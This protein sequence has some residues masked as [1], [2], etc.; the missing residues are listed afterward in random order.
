MDDQKFMN[1]YVDNAVG[2]IHEY[3]NVILQLKTKLKVASDMVLEKDEAVNALRTELERQKHSGEEISEANR[4]AK[5]WEEQYNAMK[6]KVAHM[7]TLTNQYNDL[8]KR[9]V[10]AE[11][12]I[13]SLKN[14]SVQEVENVRRELQNE[15]QNVVAQKDIEIEALK[16][17]ITKLTEK[18]KN[19]S[20]KSVINTKNMEQVNPE[21]EQKIDDF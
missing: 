10:E 6:S 3:I 21:P 9:Y 12:N 18:S 13:V 7:D 4:N 11:Q 19:S 20:K 17:K 14:Q 16:A 1:A 15:M 5:S 8:K 2:T